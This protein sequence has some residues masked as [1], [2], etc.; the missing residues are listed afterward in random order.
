MT[1][2]EKFRNTGQFIGM[3]RQTVRN[4][5]S[6]PSVIRY[7]NFF[8]YTLFRVNTFNVYAFDLTQE[9]APV[10]PVE[11]FT[12]LQPTLQELEQMRVGRDFPREFYFDQSQGLTTCHIAM[13]GSE[14]AYIHWICTQKDHSRFFRLGKGVVRITNVTTLPEF[15][16]QKLMSRMFV[17]TLADLK[18]K[19]YR[20]VIACIH[21]EN[22][23]SIK[24]ILKA[25]YRQIGTIR[26][27]GRFNRKMT[28]T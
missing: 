2:L 10:E 17:F 19:G 28:I 3:I 12:I 8:F 5:Y 11:G 7:W 6:G 20:S 25:G 27:L 21:S 4:E 14:P 16:G 13:K 1:I 15:R 23:A 22:I 24:S 26:T 9:M 18:K